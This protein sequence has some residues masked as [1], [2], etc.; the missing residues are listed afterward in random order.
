LI[1]LRQLR[2]IDRC[3]NRERTSSE[4]LSFGD[5]CRRVVGPLRFVTG[6]SDVGRPLGKVRHR[7]S[8]IDFEQIVQAFR[9]RRGAFRGCDA[10]ITRLELVDGSPHYDREEQSHR[11]KEKRF[12]GPTRS[13]RERP[14][15]S[16]SR[17]GG[18]AV[19]GDSK[20]SKA[21]GA[22]ASELAHR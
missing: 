8:P 16:C 20:L 1:G 18:P 15:Q 17:M 4:I 10:L 21:F 14:A 12:H 19:L 2:A 11:S 7:I 22:L 13:A 3:E 9:F 5:R 6:I